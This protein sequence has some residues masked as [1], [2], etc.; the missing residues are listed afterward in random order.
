MKIAQAI[1]VIS[2]LVCLIGA[3]SASAEV[4]TLMDFQGRLTDTGGN[5]VADNTYE[6]TFRIYDEGSTE[7]WSET[8][9]VTTVDGMF[10]VQLGSNGS[11]LEHYYFD[12][13]ECWLGITITGEPEMTPRVRLVTVPYA[14]RVSTI[15]GARGGRVLDGVVILDSTTLSPGLYVGK[16]STGAGSAT[17]IY[18]I[19]THVIN[20]NAEVQMVAGVHATG[21]DAGTSP[22]WVVGIY[23]KAYANNSSTALIGVKGS[24]NASGND[25]A[26]SG[27]FSS[28]Y[29]PADTSYGV[30]CVANGDLVG[31]GIHA[32]ASRF[33]DVGWGGWF[34]SS[35]GVFANPE[36]EPP[37]DDTLLVLDSTDVGGG[38]LT[39]WGPGESRN[40]R[41]SHMVDNPDYGAI[42][43]LNDNGENRAQMYINSDFG[44]GEFA[45]KGPNGELNVVVGSNTGENA[46]MGLLSIRN[47]TG[48]SRIALWC[49][50][51]DGYG[52]VLADHMYVMENS[53][54][55]GSVEFPENSIN[56]DEIL[57][58]PGLAFEYSESS[59]ALNQ[60]SFTDLET[61][62]ITIPTDGYILLHAK[63][64]VQLENSVSAN[65]AFI[66][67]DQTA[68][69][70][71]VS[72][73]AS[74]LWIGQF[75]STSGHR[76]PVSVVDVYFR[77][78]G[79]HSF[80]L[81]GMQQTS[82]G[83]AEVHR[84]VI[85]ATFIPTSYESVR[86]HVTNPA[87]FTDVERIAASG[88][89]VYKVDLRELELRAK[90]A[91]L[92]AAEAERDLLAAKMRIAPNTEATAE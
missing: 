44:H 8:H 81:E 9:N 7:R 50:E 30:Y 5:P 89:E 10:S 65:G 29:G 13:A 38:A 33:S 82:S 47:E 74:E 31:I 61:V 80:R 27:Y 76:F 26:Y 78:A 64:D 15:A 34:E 72:P 21:Y 75:V 92:R 12:Y 3:M 87:G 79:T 18:G 69:G 54:G 53:H 84:R 90:E 37:T 41:L 2:T 58:E 4:P 14:Q 55:D 20:Y 6:V 45:T 25:K 19:E 28:S 86:G 59:V 51:P 85:A 68:G 71:G 17:S 63:C 40:V 60:S 42:E 16:F 43:V 91:R 22:N 83:T 52:T 56:S 66:Q 73:T 49:R 77:S 57:N 32:R 62:A 35:V 39:T 70:T 1:P 11:P 48:E 23:G 24:V 88:Q 67:I 46:D 36:Y